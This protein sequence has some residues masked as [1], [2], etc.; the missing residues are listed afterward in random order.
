MKRFTTTSLH[1][2]IHPFREGDVG[3]PLHPLHQ[4][5]E[6][7]VDTRNTVHKTLRGSAK[8][9]PAMKNQF[10]SARVALGM[11][12]RPKD[13]MPAAPRAVPMAGRAPFRDHE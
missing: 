2:S 1:C 12:G 13:E 6:C 11:H 7:G 4:R 9:S 5:S 10:S 8:I 3:F